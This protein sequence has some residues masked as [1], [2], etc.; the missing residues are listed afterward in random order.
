MAEPWQNLVVRAGETKTITVPAGKLIDFLPSSGPGYVLGG[1]IEY[2]GDNVM[3]FNGNALINPPT[4]LIG[5]VIITLTVTKAGSSPPVT[6]LVV[7]Y[8]IRANV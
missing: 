2:S 3:P 6:F 8:R 7:T 4:L 5:P 1:K